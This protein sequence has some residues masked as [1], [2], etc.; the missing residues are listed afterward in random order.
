M[1]KV[2]LTLCLGLLG[3][4]S[5]HANTKDSNKPAALHPKEQLQKNQPQYHSSKATDHRVKRAAPRGR[6]YKPEFREGIPV[7]Y[8][9][10]RNR[11]IAPDKHKWVLSDGNYLLVNLK[12][13]QTIGVFIR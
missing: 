4:T 12:T 3:C 1:K 10:G 13:N 5:L 9:Q 6:Q 11:P 7:F 2:T 8:L